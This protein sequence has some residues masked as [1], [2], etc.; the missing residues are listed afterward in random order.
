VYEAWFNRNAAEDL[1]AL[2]QPAVKAVLARLD[3]IS[4]DYILRQSESFSRDV[5]RGMRVAVPHH[6]DGGIEWYFFDYQIAREQYLLAIAV[7]G[8]FR[9]IP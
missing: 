3:A 4:V 5:A 7:S 2:R 6:G 9:R 1:T 8:P